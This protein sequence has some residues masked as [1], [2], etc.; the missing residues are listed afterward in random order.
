MKKRNHDEDAQPKV[1]PGETAEPQA[2][3]VAAPEPQAVQEQQAAPVSKEAEY[4][5]QLVR[6]KADFENYRKRVEKEKPELIAWG[7]A[8]VTLKMLPLYDVIIH[9]K[10]ELDKITA[11]DEAACSGATKEVC[12]GLDMIFKEFEKFFA[13]ENIR[14]MES[15]GKPYDPMHHE[16]LAVVEGQD[17]NDGH[18]I[19]EVQKGFMC[20][21]KVLRPAKVC[22]ARKKQPEESAGK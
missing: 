21:E 1:Q 6:L 20:G 9:A 8:Q 2:E 4:Y 18:V 22:I 3:E 11:Q 19:Q 17:D 10:A 13:G 12:R 16:V 14:P 15:V 7:K 5:D